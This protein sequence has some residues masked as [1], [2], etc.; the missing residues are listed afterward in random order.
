MTTREALEL[1]AL[2]Q[3][4]LPAVRRGRPLSWALPR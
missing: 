2:A 1:Q 4:A 3:I